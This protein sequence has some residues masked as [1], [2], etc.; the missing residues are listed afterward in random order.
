[1]KGNLPQ[2]PLPPAL[3]RRSWDEEGYEQEEEVVVKDPS[4]VD[5]VLDNSPAV[6]VVRTSVWFETTSIF[7]PQLD[8]IACL[9]LLV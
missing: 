5:E 2:P 9:T 3:P 4:R 6:T 7:P 1:M 8:G